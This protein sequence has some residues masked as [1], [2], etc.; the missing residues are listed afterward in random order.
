MEVRLMLD[1]RLGLRPT[2]MAPNGLL[3]GEGERLKEVLDGGAEK[4]ILRKSV[5]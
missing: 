3:F 2:R 5:V 4:A 1:V